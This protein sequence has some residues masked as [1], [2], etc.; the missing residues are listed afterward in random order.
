M[1]HH[2]LFSVNYTDRVVNVDGEL[3][4]RGSSDREATTSEVTTPPA[5]N[6]G[7]QNFEELDSGFR[8]PEDCWGDLDYDCP[9]GFASRLFCPGCTG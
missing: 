4:E 5:D 1:F 8:K 9:L 2:L 7:S 6:F 3:P